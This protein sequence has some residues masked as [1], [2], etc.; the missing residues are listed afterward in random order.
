MWPLQAIYWPM[1]QRTSLITLA[2]TL[3]AHR[4]VTHFAISMRALGKGDF[5]KNMIEKGADCRTQTAAKL[6]V[7]FN[8][9]W[10]GDLEWPRHI[11]RPAKSK[12][13]AA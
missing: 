9:N 7:W 6:F 4:G 3:A 12:R 8:E 1:D 11:P 2:E 5:F 13:E 10:P